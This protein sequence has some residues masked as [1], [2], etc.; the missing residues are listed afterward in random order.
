MVERVFK[1]QFKICSKQ[2][3]E[4]GTAVEMPLPEARAFVD[5]IYD[6]LT[7]LEKKPMGKK[8]IDEIEGAGKE[9]AIFNADPGNGSAAKPYPGT[10]TN[11]MQ[12]FVQ[13]RQIPQAAVTKLKKENSRA[14]VPLAAHYAA[15]IHAVIEKSKANRTVLAS[16]LGLKAE[17]LAEVELGQRGLDDTQYQRFALFMYPHLTPG[18]G[19][20]VSF[21]F[22][23]AQALQDPN[24]SE[25]IILAHELIHAWR[26]VKGMRIFE[27]G[28]EEEAM[29]VGLP[30]FGNMPITENKIRVELGMNP[31]TQYVTRC[32]TNHFQIVKDFQG[33]KGIWPEHL[34]KWEE[35]AAANPKAAKKPFKIGS[36]SIFTRG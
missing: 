2:G 33:G 17:Q 9:V 11:E 21:R 28:W 20:T 16:I 35:W 25:L 3:Y 27:G 22:E 19:C 18:A 31:R 29:T 13:L 4:L 15:E 7:E 30:P 1:T 26:M 24:D 32:T 12:R 8:L 23:A 5:S 6:L 36:R 14:V 10:V 34:R